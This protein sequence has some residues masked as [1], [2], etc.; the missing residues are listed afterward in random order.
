M[1]VKFV[2]YVNDVCF[3]EKYE[4]CGQCEECWVKKSCFIR[5]RNKK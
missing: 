3:G 1:A 2:K 4:Q 5:F